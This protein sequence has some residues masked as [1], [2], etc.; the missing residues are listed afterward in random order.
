MTTLPGI[1]LYSTPISNANG[2]IHRIKRP[3]HHG[4]NLSVAVGYINGRAWAKCW[5]HQCA[6]ADILA[7]LGITN[8]PSIRWTPPPPPPPRPT[9]SIAPLPAVSH[10]QALDYLSGIKRHLKGA[11]V[12]YQR[13][14][15]Q[16][17][18]HWRN[19]DKR[20]NPNVT[21]D[22][23]QLRR[24]DPVDPSSAT[25]LCL[26]E[27]E[28]DAAQLSAA[29]L[30]A[31]TAPRGAQ[32]LPGADFTELVA[33]AKDTHLPVLLCGDNDEVGRKA[34]RQVRRQLQPV[35][36]PE[37]LPY[38]ITGWKRTKNHSHLDVT[39]LTGRAPEKG[40]IADL[41]QPELHKLLGLLLQ[42]LD[43]RMVKPV[44]SRMM[45]REYWCP[46]PKRQQ[47]AAGDDQNIMTFLPCGNTATCQK[48]C[49]WENF[50][51]IERCWRGEPAQMVVVSGFGGADSTIAETVG[52][53]K[54]YRGRW[55]DRLRKTSA[56]DKYQENPTSE[57]R[58]FLTAL[59]LGDDYRGQLTFFFS[60]PLSDQQLAK[61]RRRAE[62]AGL[63]FTVKDVVT[64]EDIE[65]AA[66]RALTIN[67]EGVGNTD[68]TNN[69]D[70]KP[71]AALVGAGQHLCLF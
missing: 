71:L 23:W 20:R 21:G 1:N 15:G 53:A 27:G 30:I 17:G 43:E 41:P 32:S 52:M 7:A 5:S 38:P 33:L 34:M 11:T 28:K 19:L 59:A 16:R 67:M 60:S 37:P 48:C 24:F 69:L 29:G 42:D 36:V 3:V 68:K 4:S 9:T 25:A 46:H 18:K 64:R 65:D 6:Q 47:R 35:G 50:L 13:N 12:Y 45:Y 31:F 70:F 58:K 66:P 39:D 22:G 63:A 14:D 62:R 57:R 51:H 55:Q 10:T 26:T 56:V 44:R 40:S 61:E 54:V 49:D 8:T 2:N